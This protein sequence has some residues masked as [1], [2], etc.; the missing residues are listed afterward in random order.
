MVQNIALTSARAASAPALRVDQR[1]Q[2][3]RAEDENQ[4]RCK[5]DLRRHQF[6]DEG[7]AEILDPGAADLLDEGD[8][9]V[10]GVPEDDRR[11]TSQ[12]RPAPP[13]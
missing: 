1:I 7:G 9:L 8:P 5:R 6:G 4:R 12:A 10:I 11:R 3:H 2:S 13:R